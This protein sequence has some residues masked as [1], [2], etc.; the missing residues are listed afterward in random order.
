M[1]VLK[2]GGTSVGAPERMHNVAEIIGDE[3]KKIVVLSAVSG[4]TNKLVA[5]STALLDRQ[6]AEATEIIDALYPEYLA[7]V[8]KL[9]S[10][11]EYKAV[12]NEIVNKYF[13]VLKAFCDQVCGIKEEREILALGELISTNLFHNY[14]LEIG[15][16]S[17]LLPALEFMRIDEYDEP[18]L[19]YIEEKLKALVAENADADV[20][21]TQ[22]FICRNT[23]DEVDNLK[24]GGSDYTATLIG[25]AL[26]AKEIQIWTDIDGMHNNDPRIVKGTFPIRE[27]LFEE[28]AELAYF[29]AKILHPTCIRPAADRNVPVRL[30]NTMK[31]AEKGTVIGEG[32][33]TERSVKAI[34]AKD[35]I[36]VVK[37]R[38]GRM[39]QAYGF[40]RKVFEVFEK[41][42][43]SIDVITTSEVAV[44]L[45]IDHTVNLH[46]IVEE[47]NR[48][49]IVEVESGMTIVCIVGDFSG[50]HP[51]TNEKIFQAMHSIPVR[52]ISF[53]GSKYNTSLVVKAEH[54]E[55]ALNA[56]N[57]SLF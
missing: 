22:G 41:Y 37:I 12:G 8:D 5:V 7:F 38:S 57:D 10:T 54:K 33:S 19:A 1:R 15:R 14:L 6:D 30:L 40:L 2:F 26:E 27:L 4:T 34:A 36:T 46:K 31:P 16:K 56:L 23:K 52:M 9:Y 39:L 25:A 49:A 24:R 18:R 43:T 48:V 35:D 11:E 13:G 44:S 45:T 51:E 42:K 21:I 28:A 53:G 50:E 47:L 29:G 55:A 20:F 17:V 3:H 32:T